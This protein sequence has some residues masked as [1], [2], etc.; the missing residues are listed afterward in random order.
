MI[1]RLELKTIRHKN[2]FL[3]PEKGQIFLF[4]DK[5]SV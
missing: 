5:Y 1:T 3:S 2:I 4:C